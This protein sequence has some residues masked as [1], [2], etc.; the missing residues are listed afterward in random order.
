M[1]DAAGAGVAKG[2]SLREVERTN[3]ASFRYVELQSQ[4]SADAAGPPFTFSRDPAVAVCCECNAQFHAAC[5][6]EHLSTQ[7]EEHVHAVQGVAN[8]DA[9][10]L[11]GTFSVLTGQLHR[12]CPCCRSDMFASSPAFGMRMAG[13]VWSVS[14]GFRKLRHAPIVRSGAALEDAVLLRM[15]H[16][17]DQRLLRMCSLRRHVTLDRAR[18]VASL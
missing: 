10:S 15:P 6:A 12:S 18:S 14:L 3:V 11:E 13:R 4:A 5:L 7:L 8:A 16:I 9:N 2:A 1:V 17:T